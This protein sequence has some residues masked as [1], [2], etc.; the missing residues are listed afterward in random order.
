M[1]RWHKRQYVRG[2]AEWALRELVRG[3]STHRGAARQALC[4]AAERALRAVGA[5]EMSIYRREF[6]D[7]M[8]YRRASEELHMS[9][10][11]YYRYRGRLME[12][13]EKELEK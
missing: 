7:G 5:E 8:D 11:T 3:K 4:D 1:R 2:T 9:M 13:V 10:A 6:V 12:A